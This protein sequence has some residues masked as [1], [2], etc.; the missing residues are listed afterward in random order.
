MVISLVQLNASRNYIS[1][2]YEEAFF[3][4]SK[5]QTVA[6][7][8]NS[9]IN[10]E[11]KTVICNPSLEILSLSSNQYL[12]LPE[13]APFLYSQS[14]RVLKLSDC[15]FYRLPPETFQRLPELQ[16]LNIS[17][18]KIEIL[19]SVQS[20]GSLTFLDVSHNYLTDLQ[21]DIFNALPK[22]IHLNF[23]YN[24]I[25]SLNI[26]VMPQLVKVSSS[27]DLNGNPWDCDCLMF[28]TIYSW[29]RNNSVDLD[30]VCSSPPKF[31]DNSWSIYE[32]DGCD[33]YNTDFTDQLEEVMMMIEHELSVKTHETY[34][35]PVASNSLE[36]QIQIQETEYDFTYKYISIA[37]SVVLFF[38][39][40]AVAVLSYSLITRLSLCK[41]SAQSDS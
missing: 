20:V 12:R 2:T 38:L 30:L 33:D 7:S 34:L 5:L 11:T 14:L 23:S 8:S 18:N 32:A 9:L 3:K 31:K 4:Q 41:G 39:S 21:S 15:N 40:M 16:V 36:T 6:L 29:C 27:I 17:H 10:I 19:N 24:S 37:L 35:N 28:N 22:L 26:T 13:E 25:S 1:K